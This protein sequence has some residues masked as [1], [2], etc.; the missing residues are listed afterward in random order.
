VSAA[1]A[2]VES[3][4]TAVESAAAVPVPAEQKGVAAVGIKPDSRGR[5]VDLDVAR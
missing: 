4:A 2:A 3:A 5:V 1:T